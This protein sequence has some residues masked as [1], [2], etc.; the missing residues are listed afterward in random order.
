MP[1]PS[2]PWMSVGVAHFDQDTNSYVEHVPVA[3]P[4]TSYDVEQF[5][6]ELDVLCSFYGP[7]AGLLSKLVRAGLDIPQNREQLQLAGWGYVE[8]GGRQVLPEQVNN[9]WVR[10]IDM[11]VVF[12]RAVVLTYP[13]LD[14]VS[15]PVTVVTGGNGSA[16]TSN[17]TVS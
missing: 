10:R 2:T 16:T 3:A 6:E 11:K 9:Q 5:H 17:V 8:C 7:T 12:R 15:V 4:G 14:I 13:V 1:D